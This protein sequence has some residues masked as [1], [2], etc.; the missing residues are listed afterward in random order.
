MG[1]KVV[2]LLLPVLL[3]AVSLYGVVGLLS[4]QFDE[5]FLIVIFSMIIIIDEIFR[6]SLYTPAYLTLFQP[7]TKAKRLEGHTLTKGIMEPIGIGLA[8][9]LISL[10][11][12]LDLFNLSLLAPIIL[13]CLLLWIFIGNQLFK[14]Y[15]GILKDALKS[16]LLNRGT[17]Q[18]SRDEIKILKE[19]KLKSSDPIELLYAVKML[20]NKL[21]RNEIE[22]Y[23][24]EL[25]KSD[26][27]YILKSVLEYSASNGFHI[28][29]EDL[30]NLLKH[31]NNYIAKEAFFEYGRIHKI[32]STLHFKLIFNTQNDSNKDAIIGSAIKFGGLYG[33]IE[34]G[35][36]L[37]DMI[38]SHDDNVNRQI[39]VDH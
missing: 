12:L 11:F 1:L 10:L 39:K 26:N 38:D 20:G 4:D 27:T 17:L 32:E 30:L 13:V 23:L 31:E 24:S 16:K 3:F 34:Y 37:M 29:E 7:L 22:P 35:K 8:G 18:L 33:A 21:N 25:L 14:A 6:T 36:F 9:L 15:L 19:E 2:L 28:P 5:K